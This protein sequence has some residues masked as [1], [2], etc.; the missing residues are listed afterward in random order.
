MFLFAIQSPALPR[1]T[2]DYPYLVII[3]FFYFSQ[4]TTKARYL[5]TYNLT[6]DVMAWQVERSKWDTSSFST[7]WMVNETTH[8]HRAEGERVPRLCATHAGRVRESGALHMQLLA[9]NER[10]MLVIV[11]AEPMGT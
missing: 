2:H 9:N 6:M 3:I 7:R 8:E 4:S 11:I 5:A 1:H 10:G